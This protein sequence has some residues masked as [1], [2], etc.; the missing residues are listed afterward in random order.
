MGQ[1]KGTVIKLAESKGRVLATVDTEKQGVMYFVSDLEKL[2]AG[3]SLKERLNITVE[4]TPAIK[5][6]KPY[7]T[8]PDKVTIVKATP[9][10]T[11]VKASVYG[12]IS[13]VSAGTDKVIDQITLLGINDADA[14]E[15]YILPVSPTT[16][17]SNKLELGKRVKCTTYDGTVSGNVQVYDDERKVNIN[18]KLFKMVVGMLWKVAYHRLTFKQDD[19]TE[20]SQ[21]VVEMYTEVDNLKHKLLEAYPDRDASDIGAKV[22]SNLEL[23][24]SSLKVKDKKDFNLIL[25]LTE[26]SIIANIKTEV[27]VGEHLTSKAKEPSKEP[28]KVEKEPFDDNTELGMVDL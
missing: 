11:P 10:K 25:D 2:F 26:K 14:G 13:K 8:K 21:C 23:V 7:W 1:F 4:C 15:T 28:K 3:V 17:F 6:G 5:D 20:T 27:L 12:R 9:K 22:G 24:V 16:K 19:F 18:T